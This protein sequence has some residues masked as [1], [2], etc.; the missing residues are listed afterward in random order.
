MPT[1]K[2]H[3]EKHVPVVKVDGNKVEVFVGDVEHPMVD[4]HY[5]E[6]IEIE[7][8]QGTQR[9]YLKPEQKPEAVFYL[10]EGDEFV[11]AYEHCNLHGLWV[12]EA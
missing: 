7:T 6:W 10:A 2:N 8:K 3:V 11:A 9:K 12:K 4:V 1:E 5:I